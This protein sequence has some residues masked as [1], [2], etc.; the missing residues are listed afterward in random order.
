MQ[1]IAIGFIAVMNEIKIGKIL[2]AKQDTETKELKNFLNKAKEKKIQIEFVTEGERIKIDNE[3]YLDIV[4]I[5]KDASNLN[6]NSIIA[7][8]RYENFSM[9]FTG[10][11]EEDEEKEIINKG[12]NI[13]ADVLKVA[14]HGSITSSSKDFIEKVNPKVGLIG[15]GENN[16][17]G[18]PNNK[19]IE[20]FKEMGAKVYRTD[21]MGEITITVS[22]DGKI[23]LKTKLK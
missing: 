22:K 9:L 10:D 12:G 4:Y 7:K 2:L 14:H 13:E 19:I 1:T 17:F 6:N 20:R 23:M 16:N 3:V 18:H 21:L 11:C 8:I 15:V 5:G